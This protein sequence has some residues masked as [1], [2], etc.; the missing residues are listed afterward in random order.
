MFAMIQREASPAS[1]N[2]RVPKRGN[3][4]SSL[5][6]AH[7]LVGGQGQ[8]AKHQMPHHLGRSL[9]H[10]VIC[11]KLILEPGIATFGNGTFVVSNRVGGFELLFLATPRIVVNQGPKGSIFEIAR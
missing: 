7:Q 3:G 9:D 10:Q 11:A 8:D 2:A 6:Q 4:S 5:S 1:L